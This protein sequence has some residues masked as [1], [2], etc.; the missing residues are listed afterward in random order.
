M[1]DLLVKTDKGLTMFFAAGLDIGNGYVKGAIQN[2]LSDDITAIDM[3]SCASVISH[4]QDLKPETNQVA[5][6]VDDIYN[7]LDI[8]VGSNM[9]PETRR[10]YIGARSVNSGTRPFEFNVASH[11]S[12]ANDPLSVILM[13]S[14]IAGKAVKDLYAQNKKF[15]DSVVTV[16]AVV[17]LALPIREY[18]KHGTEYREKLIKHPHMVTVHNFAKDIVLQVVLEDVAIIAEGVAAQYAISGQSEQFM[19]GVLQY[20]RK[21]MEDV[22][23]PSCHDNLLFQVQPSEVLAAMNTVG[24]DIGEGTV[25]LP[26]FRNG[27]FVPDVSSNLPIGYGS[28][29]ADALNE[30]QDNGYPFKTRKELTEY[31]NIKPSRMQ[32]ASYDKVKSIVDNHVTNLVESIIVDFTTAM[33]KAGAVVEVVYIYGGGATPIRDE[34]YR[35]LM[36][37]MR[38][39]QQEN[40]ITLYMDS[41]WSR[42]LNREGLLM[43]AK[44]KS[45]KLKKI[46]EKAAKD[47]A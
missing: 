23:G 30:L 14:C 10:L 43:I 3:P 6:V 5:G 44:M 13:L 26:V 31:L 8:V 19:Q 45:E 29:L 1:S 42:Y 9:V 34:L 2:L 40:V 32:Q 37:T 41:Q 38:V 36:E 20:A 24:L 25:N 15:P 16:H 17:S 46:A 18:V 7:Q 47:A 28:V 21:A 4:P 33:S 27:V 12:K 22:Y 39:N 35:K 11:L